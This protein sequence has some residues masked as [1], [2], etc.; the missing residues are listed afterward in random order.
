MSDITE[1]VCQ[2][3]KKSRYTV[4]LSG[5]GM[6]VESGYPAIRD[7]GESYDIEQKYGYSTEEIFSSSFFST[8][9]PQFYDF[10][11]KE[12]L[13]ALDTPP[14]KGFYEMARLEEMGIL[15]TIITRR[16]FHLPSR[17]GCKNVIEL[18]GNV[19]RNYCTHCGQ[20][21]S[22]EYVRDGEKIPLCEKCKQAIRPD[23]RLFG[24]MEDNQ[25]ITRA[26][27]E[28]QKADVLLV[29]GTNLKS[30]LCTQLLDYYEGDKLLLISKEQ[31]FSDKFADIY[32]NSRVDDALDK[33]ITEMEKNNE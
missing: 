16:I 22:M 20:E 30:Y 2:I 24:E 4:A 27:T 6:L 31:H 5:F 1:I 8:R 23:V 25:V 26:A 19:Y 17:A 14:G 18:H 29:L 9:K 3:L 13:S 32:W 12:I 11:R 33:I 15:Q 10:Y 7:G 28:I 21:Y